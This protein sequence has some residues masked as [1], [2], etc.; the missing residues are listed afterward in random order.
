MSGMRT[1]NSQEM[2]VISKNTMI[3]GNVRSFADMKIDGN[4]KGNVETTKNITINGKVVGDLTCDNISMKNSAV[5]GNV[6]LKG[7]AVMANDSMLIGDLSSQV[8]QLNGKIKG[9]IEISGKIMLD[10]DS[11]IIG[12]IK[13]GSIAISDGA[14]INGFVTTTYLS[15]DESANIFP[16]N[17]ALG[18]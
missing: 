18:D 16:E 10:R 6:R 11:V 2:T 17:I 15:K 14:V 1:D 3:D 13:A 12:D 9:N 4:I 5:Q 8:A 7:Q